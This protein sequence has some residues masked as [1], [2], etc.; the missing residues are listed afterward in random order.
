MASAL[1]LG[2]SALRISR[3]APV[4][5]MR[6]A[7]FNGMRS[8]SSSK[9]Q[10]SF[11]FAYHN[12]DF[13]RALSNRNLQTLKERFAEQLPEKIEEIKTLRK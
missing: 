6:T 5:T 4:F 3:N 7:A 2:S 8:Y 10:V 9:T 1:R 11:L 13:R 12:S